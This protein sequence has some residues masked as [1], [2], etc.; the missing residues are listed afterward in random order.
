MNHLPSLPKLCLVFATIM[1]ADPMLTRFQAGS[2]RH[3]ARVHTGHMPGL[4]QEVLVLI[5]GMGPVA[6]SSAISNLLATESVEMVINI[7]IAGALNNQLPVGK[8]AAIKS[9][10]ALTEQTEEPLEWIPISGNF[11]ADLPQ[12]RLI[13]VPEPLFDDDR[14]TVLAEAADMVDMEGAAIA[15]V[16]LQHKIPCH[17]IKGI[18]D[19]AGTGDRRD[20]QKNLT[21]VSQALCDKVVTEITANESR[22]SVTP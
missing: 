5:S 22:M 3:G 7:G 16:C 10:A 18:S 17:L 8:L 4:R 1:E 14:R 21:E 15:R 12:Y 9:V 6:S 2:V 19:S 20:L 13:S 11:S